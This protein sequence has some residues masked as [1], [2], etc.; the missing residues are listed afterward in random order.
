MVTIEGGFHLTSEGGNRVSVETQSALTFFDNISVTQTDQHARALGLYGEVLMPRGSQ[1]AR[2][3][4]FSTP[5]H[6]FS[7][8]KNG[9]SWNPKGGLRMNVDEFNTCAIEF[10]GEQCIDTFYGTCFE[11][12]F[13]SG[14]ASRE[15]GST[16]E[17]QRILIKMMQK[18]YQGLGNSFFDLY[19]FA[20]HPLIK[21]ANIESFYTAGV[22]AWADYVDQMI[23]DECGGLVTQLD[24]LAAEGNPYYSAKIPDADINVSKRKYTGDVID[25]LNSVRERASYNLRAMCDNGMMVDGANRMPA[26]LVTDDVFNAYKDWIRAKAGTNELAYRYTIEGMDGTTN[27][28]RNVLMIDSMPIVRWSACSNFDAITGAYSTRVALVSPQVFGV[29]S[30]V[31]GIQQSQFEGMGLVMQQS[32]LLKDKGKIYMTTGFRWGAGIADTDFVCMASN[33]STPR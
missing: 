10:D 20:N 30:D 3:A 23:N 17:G 31:S 13:G 32:P 12:L 14:N 22:E 2:F 29:L 28:M 26:Y 6:L 33:V 19:H 24:A 11:A 18:I 8:R 9:C 21:T 7:T 16:P 25:L 5:Q 27:L 4:S 15:F 1:K